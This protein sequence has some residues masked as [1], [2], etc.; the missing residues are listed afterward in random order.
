M[1]LNQ[2]SATITAASL[3][4][5]AMTLFWLIYGWLAFGP[6]VPEALVAF[7]TGFAASVVGYFKRETVYP[8]GFPPDGPA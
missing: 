8:N 2:P 7:S 6:P 3:A 1:P 5:G 4:S